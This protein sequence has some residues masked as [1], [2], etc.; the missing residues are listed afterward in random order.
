MGRPGFLRRGTI[1][2]ARSGIVVLRRA[3]PLSCPVVVEN[4]AGRPV[5]TQ[6]GE[7]RA[8]AAPSA[9]GNGAARTGGTRGL[10]GLEGV[11]RPHPAADSRGHHRRHRAVRSRVRR[12][13]QPAATC[14]TA[15]LPTSSKPSCAS[16]QTSNRP[17]W[18]GPWGP[19]A[20]PGDCPA[21]PGLARP[22]GAARPGPAR[23]DHGHPP[24]ARGEGPAGRMPSNCYSNTLPKNLF[25]WY[26]QR[27]GRL[28]SAAWKS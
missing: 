1:W 14:S 20:P 28:L 25:T 8:M 9:H 4:A 5:R 26:Y 22:A 6:R 15:S 13:V 27:D 21:P 10:A 7:S 17:A 24:A 19:P 23:Q 2:S 18:P 12:S 16:P 3:S 11:S